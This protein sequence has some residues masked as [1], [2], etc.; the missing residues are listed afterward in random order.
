M[1]IPDDGHGHGP[2]GRRYLVANDAIMMILVAY[3]VVISHK[4][5]PGR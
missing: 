5:V 1:V 3:T 4:N 2:G